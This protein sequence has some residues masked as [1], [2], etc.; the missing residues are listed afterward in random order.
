MSYSPE[1]YKRAYHSV[2]LWVTG[3][4]VMT[5]RLRPAGTKKGSSCC[6]HKSNVGWF[7]SWRHEQEPEKLTPICVRCAESLMIVTHTLEFKTAH[8][9]RLALFKKAFVASV[10]HSTLSSFCL[11]GRCDWCNLPNKELF[12]AR[13]DDGGCSVGAICDSCVVEVRCMIAVAIV[14]SQCTLRDRLLLIAQ[15]DNCRN[16]PKDIWHVV[17]SMWATLCVPELEVADSLPLV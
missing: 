16:T 14:D 13:A 9:M 2:P 5:V 10:S 12:C 4:A 11:V 8:I 1:D 7:V 17:C 15:S 3:G 6:G